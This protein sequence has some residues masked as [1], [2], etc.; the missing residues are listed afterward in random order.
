M[1]QSNVVFIF[2]CLNITH[3]VGCPSAPILFMIYRIFIL[4]S[5]SYSCDHLFN[6]Q[7][8]PLPKKSFTSWNKSLSIV[9]AHCQSVQIKM[10]DSFGVSH[11]NSM[12]NNHSYACV[13]IP[14]PKPWFLGTLIYTCINWMKTLEQPFYFTSYM[15]MILF[16]FEF[17]LLFF[18]FW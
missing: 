8:C 16:W 18:F 6:I 1:C 5:S 3:R 2:D 13:I 4:L 15:F 12:L 7:L 17:L 14:L 10:A 9:L 11:V